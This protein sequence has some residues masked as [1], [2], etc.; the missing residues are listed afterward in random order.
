MRVENMTETTTSRGVSRYFFLGIASIILCVSLFMSVFTPVPLTMAIVL[1]GRVKGIFLGLLG[2]VAAW[3]LA[4]MGVFPGTILIGLYFIGLI[5]AIVIAE[6]I[7]RKIAPMK[8]II[9]FGFGLLFLISGAAFYSFAVKKIDIR[10]IILDQVK[11]VANEVQAKKQE[12]IA[13]GGEESR[14]M[15]NFMSQPELVVNEVI[16]TL[17]ATIFMGIFFGLW[18]NMFIILR[19]QGLM[20]RDLEYPYKEKDYLEFTMPDWAIWVVIPSLVL[21]LWGK[22]YGVWYEATG[23]TFLKCLGLFYFFHGFGI[24]L[25]FISSVGLFG[26][27]R[28]FLILFTVVTA[29]WAISLIGLFDTWFN[30]RKFFKKKMNN[31]KD[32]KDEGDLP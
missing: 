13:Q 17:P 24:Y 4:R 14:E 25:E 21:A 20:F 27:F 5:F 26:F 16:Q 31:N 22:E 7:L 8:G 6:V 1:Y 9:S 19:S 3:G 12:Y 28:T 30:F 32:E 29:A 23:M 15:V 18:I 2:I 10:G 11:V